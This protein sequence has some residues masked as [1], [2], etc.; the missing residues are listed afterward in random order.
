MSVRI[1]SAESH[2]GRHS[3]EPLLSAL[4]AGNAVIVRIKGAVVTLCLTVGRGVAVEVGN[5][6]TAGAVPCLGQADAVWP[7]LVEVGAVVVMAGGVSRCWAG[8]RKSG[9]GQDGGGAC[10]ELLGGVHDVSPQLCVPRW[11]HDGHEGRR[12]RQTLSGDR[13]YAPVPLGTRPTTTPG[14]VAAPLPGNGPSL[15]GDERLPQHPN[16]VLRCGGPVGAGG[17][18]AVLARAWRHVRR[19]LTLAVGSGVLVVAAAGCRTMPDAPPGPA[20]E[21]SCDNP[22]ATDLGVP[23]VR[24][25]ARLTTSGGRHRFVVENLPPGSIFGEVED[26]EVQ[27]SDPGAPTKALFRVRTSL[28]QPGVVEVEAGTYIVLNT[29]RGGLEVEVC[30]D[31]TLSDV[32]PATPEQGTGVSP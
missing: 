27:L 28:Q 5:W 4:L 22:G 29:N 2:L 8:Q 7:L 12:G 19:L 20:L 18:L 17:R 25:P 24:R 21:M 26:T 1:G 10:D 11:R 31:V 23:T 32:E 16:I 9:G 13:D 3:T 15:R 30:P 6:R 14:Q